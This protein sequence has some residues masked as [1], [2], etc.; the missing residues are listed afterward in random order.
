MDFAIHA[1]LRPRSDPRLQ[2]A[3]VRWPVVAMGV[4]WEAA[5]H[6]RVNVKTPPEH[7]QARLQIT[8]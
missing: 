7:L 2:C 6:P 4:V 5:N 3:L 1:V 8:S